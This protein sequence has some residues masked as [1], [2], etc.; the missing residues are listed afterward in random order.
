[1]KNLLEKL[2]G[3]FVIIGLVLGGLIAGVF[4]GKASTKNKQGAELAE[5]K[6][7]GVKKE[8][9]EKIEN[10]SASD[11]VAN[12]DNAADLGAEVTAIQSDFRDRVRDRLNK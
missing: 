7:E 12:A 3:V 11:I 8:S 9:Y 2:K 6:A 1:M 4:F 10:T 5:L